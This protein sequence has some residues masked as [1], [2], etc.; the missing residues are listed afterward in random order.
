[1]RRKNINGDTVLSWLD[2]EDREQHQWAVSYLRKRIRNAKSY[3]QTRRGRDYEFD[4]LLSIGEAIEADFGQDAEFET[5]RGKLLANMKKAWSAQSR[6]DSKKAS[7]FRS[8][9]LTP[10]T[11][12]MLAALATSADVGED[13][14]LQ[15]LMKKPYAKLLT[16]RGSRP[17][18]GE[19]GDMQK[20]AEQLGV[21]TMIQPTSKY[22]SQAR[23]PP[24]SEEPASA[25]QSRLET[26]TAQLPISEPNAPSTCQEEPSITNKAEST[27]TTRLVIRR[28]KTYVVPQEMFERLQELARQ[29]SEFDEA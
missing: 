11:S 10:E 19:R 13:Q 6:R 1:M 7:G 12:E 28:K 17:L 9:E 23:T 27:L 15:K 21:K 29:R 3:F 5:K 8:I 16:N 2:P 18:A 25:E 14:Y 20:T 22:E 24:A 4:E 26:D